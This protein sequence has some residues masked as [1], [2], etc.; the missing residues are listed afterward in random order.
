MADNLMNDHNRATQK[1]NGVTWDTDITPADDSRPVYV[2]PQTYSGYTAD[3][4]SAPPP[5]PLTLPLERASTARDRVRRRYVKGGRNRGGEWAWVIISA[6][7]LGVVLLVGMGA[8]LLV[9]TS[10]AEPEIIPTATFPLPTA[11]VDRNAFGANGELIGSQFTLEDGRTIELRPWDGTSR[12]TVLLIGL[13]RRTGETGLAYRSDTMLLMSIDPAT[14]SIGIL[15]IPRDLYVE[16][17][18]YNQLQRV[19][20]AMVLGELEQTGYGPTL[21]MQTVQYN[22]GMYVHDYLIVDFQ[23]VISIID[24]IGGI[25]LDVPYTINDPLFPDMN[26]GYDPFYIQAGM[27]HLDGYTALKYAR[28]RHGDSDFQRAER[29]Q[30][31]ILAVRDRVLNFEMLPQLIFQAPTILNGLEDRVYT[32]MSMD[33]MI[34][35]ALYMKDIP[36][37]NIKTGVIDGNYTSPYTTPRAESVLIPNRATLG[38]LMVEIFGATYS[39]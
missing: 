26:Y 14:A 25:D 8:V 5:P 7:L 30:Q 3:S 10:S 28:T 12:F 15:S 4:K 34:Q 31:V 18:G 38:N 20:S 21:A 23:A 13:D 39:Q 17:P 27:Q 9:G 11:V 2:V 29:Q 16:V 33:Q 36:F 32:G 6:A 35:F 19:N 37:E 24:A 22:L 1:N